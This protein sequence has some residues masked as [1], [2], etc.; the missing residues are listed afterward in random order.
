MTL[1]GNS[2]NFKLSWI[3]ILVQASFCIFK[4]ITANSGGS[5]NR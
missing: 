5:V 4:M 3:F 2:G 1:V